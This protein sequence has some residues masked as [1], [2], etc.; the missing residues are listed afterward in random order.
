MQP[1]LRDDQDLDETAELCADLFTN[2]EHEVLGLLPGKD[3]PHDEAVQIGGIE[4]EIIARRRYPNKSGR[5]EL[6]V[7]I[8]GK[9]DSHG[10]HKWFNLSDLEMLGEIV[11]KNV[12]TSRDAPAVPSAAVINGG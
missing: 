11:T 9:V 4:H 3:T 2:W 10:N 12:T 6:Q 8:E 7:Q 1:F 5:Q